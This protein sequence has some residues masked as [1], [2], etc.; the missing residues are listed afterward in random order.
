M[1]VDSPEISGADSLQGP[2]VNAEKSIWKIHYDLKMWTFAPRVCF[3]FE[4]GKKRVWKQTGFEHSALHLARFWSV[5]MP[6]TCVLRREFRDTEEARSVY[7][8]VS[9]FF[10]AWQHYFT[11]KK[12]HSVLFKMMGKRIGLW[13]LNKQKK[14]PCYSKCQNMRRRSLAYY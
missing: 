12:R 13:S 14:D 10:N 3:T 7:L 4:T 8:L 9:L 2:D 1:E 11:L 6:Y 5:L